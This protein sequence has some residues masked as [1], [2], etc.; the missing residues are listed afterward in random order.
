M[1]QGNITVQR[2]LSIEGAAGR[3]Y[4]YI[5]PSVSNAPVSDLQRDIPV[6]G[7]FAGSSLCTGCSTNPSLFWYDETAGGNINDGYRSFPEASNSETLVPGRGYAVFVRGNV[8]PIAGAGSARYQLR[9]PVNAGTV[10]YNLTLTPSGIAANDGWNLIG[11]PYPSAIDWNAK[12]WT[13]TN[14]GASIYL[15]DNVAQ[16]R[17]AVWNGSVGVNGGTRYIAAGQGYF[18]KASGPAPVLTSGENVKVAGAQTRY[19]RDELIPNILRIALV[20]GS[21]RDETVLQ[22][23]DSVT[24]SFDFDF[25]A[26]KL[27]NMRNDGS[28]IPFFNVSTRSPGDNQPG[29]QCHAIGHLRNG[30]GDGPRRTCHRDF[31]NWTFPKSNRLLRM[32][33]CS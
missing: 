10:P 19:F 14:I 6:T 1:I 12:G 13:K 9:G 3:T 11:N 28:S 21:T 2:Y 17:Y 8:D 22:F 24:T 23:R 26:V 32:L 5:S 33:H 27:K 4:R 30:C 20:Q 29:N 18:I 16:G 31:T 15:L 25:D 7:N